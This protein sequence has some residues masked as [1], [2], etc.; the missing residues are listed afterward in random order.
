MSCIIYVYDCSKDSYK[1]SKLAKIAAQQKK[2][3]INIFPWEKPCSNNDKIYVALE[4]GL[5]I[6]GWMH[7]SYRTINGYIDAY[8]HNISTAQTE[9]RSGKRKYTGIGT[10]LMSKIE[11]ENPNFI[12]LYAVAQAEAFYKKIGFH[13]VDD[14]SQYMYKVVNSATTKANINNLIEVLRERHVNDI[15]VR[16]KEHHNYVQETLR[17]IESDIESP[18]IV[19]KFKKLLRNNPDNI[20]MAIDLY[21][22]DATPEEMSEWILEM[23]S[24]IEVS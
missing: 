17:I 1:I 19:R 18:E 11:E 8:V 13:K 3:F 21:E 22:N 5:H 14:K 23:A 7:V 9:T 6:C 24:S 15:K 2:E 12:T 16:E 20:D 4:R 10:K